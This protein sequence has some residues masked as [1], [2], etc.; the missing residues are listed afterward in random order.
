MPRLDLKYILYAE[1][2]ADD[3][4][5]IQDMMSSIDSDLEI[6]CVD[7]GQL[8]LSHLEELQ[9]G[10]F[11]PSIIIL[12][13]N[14]PT[15][16]GIETLRTLKAHPKYSTI[17]VIIF[18]TSNLEKDR[19]LALENGASHFITKPVHHEDIEQICKRFA[20]FAYNGPLR[21]CVL[22]PI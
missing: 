7:N 18:S 21:Y 17:P 1:D 11:L 10:S 5:L 9:P 8:L 3:Q 16:D 20:E 14:M 2:D 19:K 4:D 13:M 12:D 15:L 6:V 22:R